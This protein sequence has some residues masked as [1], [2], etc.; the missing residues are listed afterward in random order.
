MRKGDRADGQRA[1]V[2][3]NFSTDDAGEKWRSKHDSV[4]HFNIYP[5]VL[6]HITASASEP[7]STSTTFLLTPATTPQTDACGEYGVRYMY[8][9]PYHPALGVLPI[10]ST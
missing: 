3:G 6:Y 8:F 5:P 9:I 10:C 4:Q 1:K 2:M 7:T